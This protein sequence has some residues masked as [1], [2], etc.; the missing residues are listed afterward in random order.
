MRAF[1]VGCFAALTIAI[2]AAIVLDGLV[3]ELSL[4]SFSYVRRSPLIARS[5]SNRS[6]MH[7][8]W[9][10]SACVLDAVWLTNIEWE[11]ARGARR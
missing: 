8:F 4:D 10:K 1:L 2:A 5:C 7:G 6:G 3:Q 11:E 9:M